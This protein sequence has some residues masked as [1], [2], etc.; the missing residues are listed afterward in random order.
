MNIRLTLNFEHDNNID[1]QNKLS[2]LWGFPRFTIPD[3]NELNIKEFI[4]NEIKK[5]LNEIAEY[6][7]ND[8]VKK[9]A[10]D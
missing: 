7:A 10:K 8:I 4:S 5:H 2:N 1:S 3:S 6:I 9:S